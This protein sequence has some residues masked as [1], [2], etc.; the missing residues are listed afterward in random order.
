MKRVASLDF[1]RGL[2]AFS[3]AIPH[4]FS[5]N[6][7][8]SPLANAI[9]VTGVEVFFVLSGFVLAPQILTMVVGGPIRYLRTFI[10]RRWMRTIPPY[11]IA[12]IFVAI[13]T[14]EL[15]TSDFV[16]YLFYIQ[17][18][19]SQ[20]NINDF[21][22]IAWSLSVEEWFYITFAP[23]LFL[24]AKLFDR[25][26]GTF[27]VVFGICFILSITVARH[28]GDHGNWDAAVRRVTIFRID[29]IAWGFLLYIATK[30]VASFDMNISKGWT[31]LAA[32]TGLFLACGF[33]GIATAYHTSTSAFSRQAFPFVAAAFGISA[34]FL[35]R[36]S[37]FLFV[38]N[39]PRTIGFFLGHISYSVYLFHLL[40]A[41]VIKPKLAGLDTTLQLAIFVGL[42]VCLTSIIWF[43]IEKPILAARPKYDTRETDLYQALDNPPPTAPKFLIATVTLAIVAIAFSFYCFAAYQGNHQRTFYLTLVAASAFT[44]LAASRLRIASVT[45]V[46]LT[47]FFVAILLPPADYLFRKSNNAASL[48]LSLP[49]Q[50]KPA[51]SF[52]AGKADPR[53][54]HAWW[55]HYVDQWTKLGGGKG[56]TEEPDPNGLLPFV[57]IPNSTGRFF[58]SVIRINNL[59]FRGIDV[60][61]DK[62]DRFRIFTLGESPTFGPTLLAGDRTWPED[63]QD[64]IEIGLTCDRPIE[65]INAG[66]EAYNLANNT[67]RLQRDIIP[68]EPDLVISYHGYNGLGP[69]FGNAPFSDVGQEPRRIENRP[70][71]L[72]NEISY[73]A[74]LMV[75]RLRS[76]KVS[77]IYTEDQLMKTE[78]ANSYRKLLRIARDNG[79]RVILASSSMAVGLSSP[80]EVKAFY[81]LVFT[82][83]DDK[84]IRNA[85]HNEMV[86]KIAADENV[87][88]ID[89]V[90][91]L[92]GFWDDDLYLDLVH[93]TQAGN[94]KMAKIVFDGLTDT[95]RK[96]PQLKCYDRK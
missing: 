31:L 5:L 4:Y 36:Q 65:V 81:G 15:L 29:S 27:A 55:A 88:F 26:D 3:V 25:K 71:A 92:D 17:N 82:G 11:L 21:F 79:F 57:L 51:Y 23:L 58:D 74:R 1:L 53:A 49:T 35:F 8:E 28:F 13:V 38:R 48:P 63:L 60:E 94:K 24:L 20:A 7:A 64:L 95:L 67:E 10:I 18:L 96:D 66:T 6:V 43:Y 2:A 40:L 59:G 52:K 12:L 37:E 72:L 87:P 45:S 56:A 47:L 9:A 76:Q 32:A 54:F 33:L 14:G 90:P 89:T 73:R 70:S 83:I 84:I 41:M 16:R 50:V 77:P 42:L 80:S 22:A 30:R 85:A 86:R 75:F 93:F 68:L 44:L 78:Y 19:F 91:H 69:L 62:H 34:V 39:V 46:F 61:R